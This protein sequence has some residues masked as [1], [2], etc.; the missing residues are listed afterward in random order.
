MERTKV[1]FE[2]PRIN[3]LIVIFLAICVSNLAAV[4]SPQNLSLPNM[5]GQ[6]DNSL[7]YEWRIEASEGL[8]VQLTFTSLHIEP[9]C[10]ILEVIFIVIFYF[11]K[12][13]N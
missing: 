8:Q 11:P 12:K 10:D 6:Y 13:F 9:C 3:T 4:T 2:L 5:P 7:Q 1:S